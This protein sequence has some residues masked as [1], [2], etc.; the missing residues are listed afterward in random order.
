[1][2]MLPS[3]S[4]RKASPFSQ[5]AVSVLGVPTASPLRS[6][7]SVNSD[8][9]ENKTPRINPYLGFLRPPSPINNT[10]TYSTTRALAIAPHTPESRRS[11][12]GSDS[13]N[14]FARRPSAK[15]LEPVRT[16]PSD[17]PQSKPVVSV[18]LSPSE[19]SPFRSLEPIPDDLRLSTDKIQPPQDP[20]DAASV[21]SEVDLDAADAYVNELLADP[22]QCFC[23]C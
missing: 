21:H 8:G 5:A 11:S 13:S 19:M 6:P 15:K 4:N 16:P 9:S 22:G 23:S 14:D 10:S 20:D 12:S 3:V 18:I 7:S 2:K 1:M 17:R